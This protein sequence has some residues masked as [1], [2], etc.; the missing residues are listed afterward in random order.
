MVDLM[1]LD[2]NKHSHSSR[3]SIPFTGAGATDYSDHPTACSALASKGN[4]NPDS[5]KEC[6]A[7]TQS[8]SERAWIFRPS[9]DSVQHIFPCDN[10]GSQKIRGPSRPCAAHGHN[11]AHKS[12]HGVGLNDAF[13]RGATVGIIGAQK[14]ARRPKP[15]FHKPLPTARN[16]PCAA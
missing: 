14:S 16:L 9:C 1:S 5:S 6:L 2:P 11:L 8:A 7:A 10:T 3:P 13:G 12:G 15:L 4:I